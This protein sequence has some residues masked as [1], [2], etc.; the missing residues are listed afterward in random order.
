MVSITQS[1][2]LPPKEINS[3]KCDD[4]AAQV[5]NHF[6]WRTAIDC[7]V[8]S[9][10]QYSEGYSKADDHLFVKIGNL[11]YDAETLDG[12]ESHPQLPFYQRRAEGGSFP[13]I[14]QIG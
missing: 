4:W 12:V 9:T 8:W 5:S 2:N 13:N 6:A 10:S 11:F 7:E 14:E 3:G 1:F